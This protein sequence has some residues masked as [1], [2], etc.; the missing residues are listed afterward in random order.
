MRGPN[1]TAHMEVGELH[2]PP[3][4]CHSLFYS[5]HQVEQNID[6]YRAFQ[7]YFIKHNPAAMIQRARYNMDSL[8]PLTVDL[9]KEVFANLCKAVRRHSWD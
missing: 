3:E 5:P 8:A 9:D 7:Q 6:K 4:C 1:S 2:S